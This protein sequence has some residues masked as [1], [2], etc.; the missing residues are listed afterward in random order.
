MGL[1]QFFIAGIVVVVFGLGILLFSLFPDTDTRDP[2]AS[3]SPTATTA[4]VYY[5]VNEDGEKLVRV[6]FKRRIPASH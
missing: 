3:P 2:N 4:P 1:K 6:A 5:I